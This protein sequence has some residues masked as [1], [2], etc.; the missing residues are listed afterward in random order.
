M[1]DDI[2]MLCTHRKR[3]RERKRG[4]RH[5]RQ[6]VVSKRQIDW[7]CIH[8]FCPRPQVVSNTVRQMVKRTDWERGRETAEG[9]VG[10]R[11]GDKQWYSRTSSACGGIFV[12]SRCVGFSFHF[13]HKVYWITHITQH[14][15]QHTHTHSTPTLHTHVCALSGQQEKAAKVF[16]KLLATSSQHS[17]P[18]TIIIIYFPNAVGREEEQQEEHPTISTLLSKIGWQIPL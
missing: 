4:S 6:T 10:E 1:I 9:W 5:N 12:P 17:K 8:I 18:T 13:V 15:H 3:E 2:A 11:E 16:R 14:I 7:N